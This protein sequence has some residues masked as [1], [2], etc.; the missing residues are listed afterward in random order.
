M[1]IKDYIKSEKGNG[2]KLAQEV[3]ISQQH[4]YQI[5]I[6]HRIPSLSTEAGRD[7]L[8]KIIDATHGLVTL[9]DLRPEEFK[10]LTEKRRKKRRK[11]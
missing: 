5:G 8:K 1:T 9:E 3:G 4:L 6:G 2:A 7:L 10:F 11:R